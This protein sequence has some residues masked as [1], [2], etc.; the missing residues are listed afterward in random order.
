MI[1]NMGM[2]INV[3]GREISIGTV[4]VAFCC[5]RIL[6][7]DAGAEEVSHVLIAVCLAVFSAGCLMG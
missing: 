2:P 4:V 5:R 7:H 6:C 1:P 3:L